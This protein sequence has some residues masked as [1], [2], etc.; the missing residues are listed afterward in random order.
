MSHWRQETEL[1]GGGIGWVQGRTWV[2]RMTLPLGLVWMGD[3]DRPPPLPTRL[4]IVES[5]P[6][7][8]LRTTITARDVPVIDTSDP[9]LSDSTLLMKRGPALR[10]LE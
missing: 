9:P 5:R 7:G 1:P 2:A 4:Y 3:R 6:A 8:E 10:R